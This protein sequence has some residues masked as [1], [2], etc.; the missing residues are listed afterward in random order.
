MKCKACDVRLESFDSLIYCR[1]CI[2][3][4]KVDN[5]LYKDP[6]HLLITNQKSDTIITP[7]RFSR[8]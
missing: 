1:R 5:T 3:L 4:S 2:A 6:Q 7:M 8:D